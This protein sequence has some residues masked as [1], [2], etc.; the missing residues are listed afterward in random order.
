MNKAGQLSK[1]FHVPPHAPCPL[2]FLIA[3]LSQGRLN[4]AENV[5]LV[6]RRPSSGNRQEPRPGPAS[7]VPAAS[8]HTLGAA[9][10]VAG[11]GVGV[12][13]VFFLFFFF[14]K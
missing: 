3:S 7:S 13:W 8:C 6:R 11:P 2:R 12:I 10:Q 9:G 14:F 5:G 4:A 1:S